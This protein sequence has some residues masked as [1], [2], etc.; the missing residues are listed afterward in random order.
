MQY[1][2][3]KSII[4]IALA[5]DSCLIQDLL[6]PH[7]D[8]IDNCKIV[9][10]A[11]NGR[12]LLER[13]RQKPDT[14]MIIMDIQMPEMDGIDAAKKVMLEFPGIKVL[15]MSVFTNELACCRVISA[16]AH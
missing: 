10:Q 12:E 9:V 11:N 1:Q 16:G 4:K 3:G 7:I 13:L 8:S 15:F 5:D 2:H 14:N 6:P